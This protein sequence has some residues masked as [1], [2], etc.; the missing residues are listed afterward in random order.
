MTSHSV[1]E[2]L[3][4]V[5]GEPHDKEQRLVSVDLLRGLVMVL[6]LLDHVRD[7]LGEVRRDPTDLSTTT[8]ALFLTRWVTHFCAPVFVLLAGT[9]A[10]LARTRFPTRGALAVFLFTR[11]LWLIV[12]E[13]TV[14][15]FGLTFDPT[16][17]FIPLTVIWVIGVS[18][19]VLSVLVFLP[20]PAVAAFGLVMIACH[21]AFDGV[22]IEGQGIPALLWRVLHEQALLGTVLGRPVFVA[23]PLIPWIGVMAAG[24]G[25]GAVLRLEPRRRRTLLFTAGLALTAAFVLLRAANVYGD[26]RPWSSQS[27]ST[28]AAL[29]FLN[30][31]KYPPSLLFLLMTLGPALVALALLDGGLGRAGRPLVIFGR[32]PLFY[33]LSQWYL[34]HVLAIVVAAVRGEPY[35]WL[36]GQGPFA[37]PDGYGHSLPFVYAVWAICLLLLYPPCA[38][39]AGLK[40]R[41]HDA[42]LSYL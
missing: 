21:N 14:V 27:D 9:G 32:V 4:N 10:Y 23:Y 1:S 22:R 38:W 18:M 40:Q 31:T 33:Y 17:G 28:F 39:F 24:Y 2:P 30:C 3:D 6:M 16:F 5:P 29:S 41:R 15:R 7:F 26:P 25:L 19:I 13:I 12:L 35:M 42:W 34:I 8:V 11:G 36:I 37:A 20:T